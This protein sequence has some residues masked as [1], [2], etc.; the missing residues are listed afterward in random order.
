MSLLD[1]IVDRAI[2]FATRTLAA[3][4]SYRAAALAGLKQLRESLSQHAPDDP[5]LARL[6]AYLEKLERGE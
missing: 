2:D 3:L 5:A 6:D 4:P 1:E